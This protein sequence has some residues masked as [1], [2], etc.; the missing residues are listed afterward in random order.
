MSRLHDINTR[1]EDP[2]C[3]GAPYTSCGTKMMIWGM[4]LVIWE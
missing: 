4:K 3:R 2:P 1:K